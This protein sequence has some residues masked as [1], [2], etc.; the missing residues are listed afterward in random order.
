MIIIIYKAMKMAK[1]THGYILLCLTHTWKYEV[2][3]LIVEKTLG[4]ANSSQLRL[5]LNSKLT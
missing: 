3:L 2:K 4:T 5:N 1:S